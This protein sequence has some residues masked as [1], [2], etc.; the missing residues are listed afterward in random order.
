VEVYILYSPSLNRLYVGMTG[1]PRRR[2]RQHRGKH[3]GWMGRTD[4]WV[5]VWSARVTTMAE[6]RT[7]EK[8]IKARD[9]AR[10]L[11]KQ[12]V[13]QPPSAMGRRDET[14]RT[15]AGVAKWL[16]PAAADRRTPPPRPDSDCIAG[17]AA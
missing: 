1:R 13:A 7:L 10:W 8:A 14:A 4:D 12:G 17:R 2:L 15:S 11:A 6:A 5:I 9:A 16:R 3:E